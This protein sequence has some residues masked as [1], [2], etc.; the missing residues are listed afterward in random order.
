MEPL[1]EVRNL[2][3]RYPDGTQALAGVDFRLYAGETVALLGPNGSGKTTFVLHLNGLLAGEG[4]I[5]V[6]GLRVGKGTLETIRRKVGLLFQNPDEQLF[7]PTLVEDVAFGPL[8]LGAA[9]AEARASAESALREVGL[10]AAFDKAPYHLSA[11]E[12]RRAALAAVLVMRPEI[13]ILDE[14]TTYL[15]PPGQR[16]LADLLHRLPQPKIL[17]THDCSLVR[18]LATRALFF[19]RGRIVGEGPVEDVLRRFDWDEPR[20]PGCR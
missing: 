8:N 10:E 9:P 1:I 13:L 19:Q 2:R 3:F 6:T 12:K 20:A 7:M 4:E 5:F 17:V 14:P 18:S 15:D 11:G 16:D